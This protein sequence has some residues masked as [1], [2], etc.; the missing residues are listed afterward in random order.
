MTVEEACGEALNDLRA[1]RR[2][3]QGGVTIHALDA[4]GNHKWLPSAAAG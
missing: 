4:G 3:F 2:D 1:L